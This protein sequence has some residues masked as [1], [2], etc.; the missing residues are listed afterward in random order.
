MGIRDARS[1]AAKFGCFL[2]VGLS[3]AAPALEEVQF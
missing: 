3:E 2:K 1:R